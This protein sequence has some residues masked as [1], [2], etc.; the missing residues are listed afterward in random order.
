MKRQ[1]Y[2]LFLFI[3]SVAFCQSPQYVEMMKANISK[4]EYM[5]P[6]EELL[7]AV[8]LMERVAGAE[9]EEWLPSYYAALGAVYLAS[10]E[11][12]KGGEKLKDYVDLAARHLASA[13]D[14][15]PDNSEVLTLEGYVNMAHIWLNPMVNGAKYSPLAMAAFQ[16]AV[17]VDPTN[18]R[19]DYLWG[20]N[21]FYTPAAF[22][23]GKEAAKE[24]FDRANKKFEVFKPASSIM[25]T[26][27][28]PGND[29]FLKMCGE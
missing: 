17:E 28:K 6:D 3:A 12:Q 13:K 5:T 9:E 19:P 26:W 16:K 7:Q 10:K 4:I 23:G 25:P 27:G 8:N 1:I 2:F 14:K 29:Y 21:L 20:Q 11:M 18:P 22:G 15:A 24:F